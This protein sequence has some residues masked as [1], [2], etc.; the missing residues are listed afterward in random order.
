MKKF[1]E[2]DFFITCMIKGLIQLI[3][4]VVIEGLIF[5]GIIYLVMYFC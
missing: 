3:I 4:A 2:Y 5:I 1:D